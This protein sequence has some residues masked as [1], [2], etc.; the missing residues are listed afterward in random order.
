MTLKLNIEVAGPDR[1]ARRLYLL[2]DGAHEPVWERMTSAAVV[3]ILAL[4]AGPFE[5]DTIE[6]ESNLKTAEN[7]LGKERAFTLLAYRA[8]S[9]FELRKRLVDDGYPVELASAVVKRI[10][11]LGY[12]D[13]RAFAESLVRMKMASGWGERKIRRALLEKGVDDVLI[14]EVWAEYL[15]VDDEFERALQLVTGKPCATRKERDRLLRRIVSRGFSP[16]VAY[17]VL[18]AVQSDDEDVSDD[19]F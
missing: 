15:G 16:G 7:E 12:L 3:K 18:R 5:K 14:D 19:A 4:E 9:R 10:A 6:L 13:D 11:E 1:K 17:S 8:R 2:S